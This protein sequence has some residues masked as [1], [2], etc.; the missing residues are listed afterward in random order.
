MRT[1][2]P[3]YLLSNLSFPIL[4]TVTF[5]GNSFNSSVLISSSVNWDSTFVLQ[6]AEAGV[7]SVFLSNWVDTKSLGLENGIF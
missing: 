1:L 7:Y 2:E 5:G 6:V 3:D 4:L